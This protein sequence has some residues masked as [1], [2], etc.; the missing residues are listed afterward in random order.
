VNID[1]ALLTAVATLARNPTIE[2][3][4]IRNFSALRISDSTGCVS[5]ISNGHLT[6]LD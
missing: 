4:R 5:D 1:D 3:L 2:K 6:D